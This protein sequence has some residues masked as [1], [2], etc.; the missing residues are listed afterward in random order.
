MAARAVGGRLPRLVL[1]SGPNCSLCDT[2]KVALAKVRQ[3]RPFELDTINIQDK[4]QEVW[5]KKSLGR[6]HG[7]P[8]PSGMGGA[9]SPGA[10]SNV[11][12]KFPEL[13]LP[14]FLHSTPDPIPGW[15]PSGIYH[16][17]DEAILGDNDD[18]D[19][20]ANSDED[21][22]ISEISR[23]FNCGEAD[24]KVPDCPLRS[25]RELISLSRQYYQFYQGIQGLRNWKRV[26]IVEAWRQ[27]RLDWLEEFQPGA[28][29]GELLQ[30]ALAFGNDELLKNISAWGYPPGW[31]SESDPQERVRAR[32]LNEYD[33][34]AGEE[35]VEISFQIHGE[36]ETSEMLSLHSGKGSA[37]AGVE[38]CRTT[39]EASSSSSPVRWANYPASYF[40]SQHLVLYGPPTS[41]EPHET[42][43]N[44]TFNSSETYLHQF[45]PDFYRFQPPPPPDEPPPLPPSPSPSPLPPPVLPPLSHEQSSKLH[46]RN[47]ECYEDP[48]SDM[49]LSDLE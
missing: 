7:G 47:S 4:G 8:G 40:S 1:F 6:E 45:S 22:K 14:I 9:T 26:H 10:G 28:I 36:D 19:E 30:D 24:H 21:K 35:D 38:E 20:A 12:R 34:L 18:D 5:K 11:D 31:V 3:S 42:W 13:V 23:C 46:A 44:T 43:D 49:D 39:A 29:K 16:R 27:Q 32:I 15:E 48:E 2:A 25:N 17:V 33:R 41:D 37:R